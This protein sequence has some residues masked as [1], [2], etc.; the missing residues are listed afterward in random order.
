MAERAAD[1][2]AKLG[3]DSTSPP[4]S[5]TTLNSVTVSCSVSANEDGIL[6]TSPQNGLATTNC[7]NAHHR[8]S[9]SLRE[10]TGV[11]QRLERL[12]SGPPPSQQ[13][14]APWTVIKGANIEKSRPV[15]IADFSEHV[16]MMSADS[17]FRFSEEYEVIFFNLHKTK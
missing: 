4:S 11:D 2:L 7:F 6:I 10:R 15:R 3:L 5:A 9:R 16:R 14:S 8:R 12:P 17:D 13:K 1:C